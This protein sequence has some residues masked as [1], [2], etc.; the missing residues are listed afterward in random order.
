MKLNPDKSSVVIVDSESTAYTGPD[1]RG[2][3]IFD[4]GYGTTNVQT[5]HISKPKG[6]LV[7]ESIKDTRIIKEIENWEKIKFASKESVYSFYKLLSE[8]GWWKEEIMQ[9]GDPIKVMFGLAN[10]AS[11]KRLPIL[12]KEKAGLTQSADYWRGKGTFQNP[13]SSAS[14]INY[15]N[16]TEDIQAVNVAI[17]QIEDFLKTQDGLEDYLTKGLLGTGNTLDKIKS[18]AYLRMYNEQKFYYTTT[19]FKNDSNLFHS[20]SLS[21]D[22]ERWRTI[23]S[24][25][26]AEMDALANQGKLLGITAYG[27]AFAEKR[28]IK[29]TCEAYGTP[30][31]A[32][33]LDKYANFCLMNFS[34]LLYDLNPQEVI[35][36]LSQYNGKDL[37]T[38]GMELALSTQS[39]K[40]HLS[41]EMFYEHIF[42]RKD[43]E[44]T[45]TAAGDVQHES[46]AFIEAI[47]KKILPILEK[48]R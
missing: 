43:F 42:E 39:W 24:K 8:K 46:E 45:H 36:S 31:F 23:M 21:Y 3:V 27:L 32:D 35:D 19:E 4:F 1:G 6:K 40:Q 5:G 15:R 47:G 33:I 34:Q 29:Q 11:E 17:L 41:F 44:Q 38:E 18:R 12:K 9:E 14:T 13:S 7:Y 20:L 48:R 30:E 16:R 28:F 25:F 26:Q 37:L 2:G 10:E 22:M